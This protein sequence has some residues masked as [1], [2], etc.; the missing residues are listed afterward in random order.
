MQKKK[1]NLFLKRFFLVLTK[2]L[3]LGENWTQDDNY[4]T[5]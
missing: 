1:K 5:F 3:P 2:F 4:I